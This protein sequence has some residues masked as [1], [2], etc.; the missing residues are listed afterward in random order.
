MRAADMLTLRAGRMTMEALDAIR[1]KA[2]RLE[3]ED[4][5]NAAELLND[6]ASLVEVHIGK[7]KSAAPW[8][9]LYGELVQWFADRNWEIEET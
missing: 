3:D 4:K 1:E 8:S 9:E 7:R 5:P 2:E 6:L